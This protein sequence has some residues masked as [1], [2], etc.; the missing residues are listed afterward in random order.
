MTIRKTTP[1]NLCTYMAFRKIA[2]TEFKNTSRMPSMS[3]AILR[4]VCPHR[5]LI[6][7]SMS[8][9]LWFR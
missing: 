2:M 8:N 6:P 1:R 9:Q 3:L 5:Q 7:A 4:R